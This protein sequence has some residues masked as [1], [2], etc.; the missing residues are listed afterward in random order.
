MKVWVGMEFSSHQLFNLVCA[1]SKYVCEA[2]YLCV[3]SSR[4]RAVRSIL[5]SNSSLL[6]YNTGKCE[7][8]VF[9]AR[10]TKDKGGRCTSKYRLWV[11]Q[12][13]SD[14]TLCGYHIWIS[15]PVR[16]LLAYRR[17]SLFLLRTGL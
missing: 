12:N 17:Q 16:I 10:Q 3:D 6:A 5:L 2:C 7:S 13:I 9:F 11:L 14:G 8:K 15:L 4:L 1:G